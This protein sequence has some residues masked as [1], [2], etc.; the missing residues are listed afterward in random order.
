VTLILQAASVPEIGET[1]VLDMG[2]PIR[3]QD[4]ARD[5]ARMAGV[6]PD[7]LDIV[8]TG[9]RPGERLHEIPLEDETVTTQS[10]D[11]IW[12]TVPTAPNATADGW[13]DDL[14]S[15]AR[16]HDD[17]GVRESLTRIGVLSGEVSPSLTA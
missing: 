1:Y 14:V 8:F 9:L 3:I 17:L 2:E 5:I 11:R 10:H 4:L 6:D 7:E 15:A 13:I 16:E 12:K